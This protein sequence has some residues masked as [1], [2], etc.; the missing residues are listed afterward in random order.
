MA[1]ITIEYDGRST[2]IKKLIELITLSGGKVSK[3]EMN[4]IDQSL[5]DFDCGRV[6]HCEDFD[7]FIQKINS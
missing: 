6:T 4:S 2:I 1:T 3:K 5:E 7:D